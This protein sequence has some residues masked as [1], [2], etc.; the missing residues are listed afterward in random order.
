M[1]P[2]GLNESQ[3]SV[4]YRRELDR[5]SASVIAALR[6]HLARAVKPGVQVVSVE[7]FVDEYGGAPS[8]YIYYHGEHNKVDRTDQSLFAGRA[9]DLQLPLNTLAEFDERYFLS[10]EDGEFEFPGLHLAGNILKSWVAEC[11]W[12]AG[13]WTYPVP[14]TVS[15][16]D[17]RGD[18]NAI[19]LTDAAR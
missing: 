16:H 11:W 15:V 6:S 10:L 7:I 13:G 2:F 17:D 3:F 12:K 8:A 9:M 14:T 1:I 4:R 5:V 18:G 19:Q